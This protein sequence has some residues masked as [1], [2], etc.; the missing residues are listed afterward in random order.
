[1]IT[2]FIH[3]IKMLS[4]EFYNDYDINNFPEILRKEKR[5]YNIAIFDG[6]GDYFICVPFRSNINHKYAYRFKTSNRSKQHKSGLDYQKMIII[7]KNVYIDASNGIIDRDEYNEYIANIETINNNALNF[8]KDY[9][10]YKHG[11]QNISK[12]EFE[13]RYR[14]SPLQYFDAIIL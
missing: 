12:R 13:R 2:N 1:M 10:D 6:Y 11:T 7:N 5:N 4:H 14:F 3:D 9:I 8:L